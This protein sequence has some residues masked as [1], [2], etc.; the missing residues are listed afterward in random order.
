MIRK[1]GTVVCVAIIAFLAGVYV[2]QGAPVEA[3]MSNQIYELRTYTTGEGNLQPLLGRFGG[4]EIEIFHA[5]GM[6]SVGYWVPADAPQSQNT[7]VYMLAH[8]SREA[9][10]ASWA[11]FRDDPMWHKMRDESTRDGKLV[12]NVESLFLAPTDFSPAK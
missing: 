1:Y 6:R 2:D 7:L 4:G 9:A 3:Q 12:T 10:A 8:A 11:G 5:H